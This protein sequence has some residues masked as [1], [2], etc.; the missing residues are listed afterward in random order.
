M[1][2]DLV[3]EFVAT[4]I[5]EWNRLVAEVS[6]TMEGQQRELRA[7]ERKIANLGDAIAEG[8]R[9]VAVHQRLHD[10]E[11]RRAELQSVLRNSPAPLP[12]L[13]PNLAEVYH[14][15][16]A[17]L[18]QALGKGADPEAL[19]A[20]RALIDRVIVSPPPGG[21]EP[22]AVEL[23]GA[24]AASLHLGVSDDNSAVASAQAAHVFGLFA[25][26]VKKASGDSVPLAFRLRS[27]APGQR[28]R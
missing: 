4:F 27:T 3:K 25:N 2:P 16:V 18:Q 24:L 5:G 26:S 22:P 9:G 21:G 15:K 8:T 28:T 12:A 13:H 1:R 23:V 7:V 14:A 11:N 10:L 20:A 19:E 6:G 17:N